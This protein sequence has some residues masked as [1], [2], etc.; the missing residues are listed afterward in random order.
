VLL[1]LGSGLVLVLVRLRVLVLGW[2]LGLFPLLL[3]GL[4]LGLFM[5]LRLRLTLLMIP[6]SSRQ[7][8]HLLTHP[9][10]RL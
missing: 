9:V 7:L 6:L 10:Q 2:T 3:P 5:E 8:L 4:F 1:P